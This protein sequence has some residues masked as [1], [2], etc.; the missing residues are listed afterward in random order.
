VE[1]GR[2]RSRYQGGQTEVLTT[3]GTRL[4]RHPR[5]RD[6]YPDML[7]TRL[8]GGSRRH[9]HHDDYPD[10]LTTA[11]TRLDGGSRHHRHH[12]DYPEIITTAGTGI[13]VTDGHRSYRRRRHRRDPQVVTTSGTQVLT[14][15]NGVISGATVV[16]PDAPREHRRRRHSSHSHRYYDPDRPSTFHGFWNRVLGALTGNSRRRRYGRREMRDASGIRKAK[17]IAQDVQERGHKNK[18]RKF[19]L[20]RKHH[21]RHHHRDEPIIINQDTGN[22][23]RPWMHHHRMPTPYS[24]YGNLILG[25]LTGNRQ[26]RMIGSAMVAASREQRRAER[27]RRHD[28]LSDI[29]RDYRRGGRRWY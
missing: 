5:H 21:D 13:N 19:R 11:G 1:F 6:D 28:D 29:G 8:D 3:A 17:H 18:L 20:R 26:K 14:T 27:Q 9:R 16:T 12:D 10:M 15:G 7:G 4:S 23:R 24:G 25:Y 22:G 2:S